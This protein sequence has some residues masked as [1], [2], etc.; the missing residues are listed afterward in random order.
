[1]KIL[2]HIKTIIMKN[3]IHKK[4]NT[5]NTSITY[6]GRMWGTCNGPTSPERRRRS[7]MVAKQK[8]GKN[9]RRYK[10]KK[11]AERRRP[12]I[13]KSAECHTQK[14]NMNRR[15]PNPKATCRRRVL[16]YHVKGTTFLKG[17]MSSLV[18]K[19]R[20]LISPPRLSQY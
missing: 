18:F 19:S 11:Y 1:M 5:G 8:A 7:P 6:W 14:K 15:K 2:I 13:Q 17:Y 20:Q 12:Y 9:L 4:D 16:R 3:K 10:P